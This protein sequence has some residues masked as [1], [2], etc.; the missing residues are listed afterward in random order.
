MWPLPSPPGGLNPELDNLD[1][2]DVGPGPE[3]PEEPLDKL[4]KDDHDQ[5]HIVPL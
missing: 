3:L 1:P 4:K 2:R 5:D